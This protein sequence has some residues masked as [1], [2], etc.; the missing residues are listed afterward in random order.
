[1]A[2]ASSGA[3]S[4]SL[5]TNASAFSVEPVLATAAAADP[6][7]VGEAVPVDPALEAAMSGTS[8]EGSVEA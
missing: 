5:S 6:V 7:A 4:S 2:S 1:M 3:S 8:A